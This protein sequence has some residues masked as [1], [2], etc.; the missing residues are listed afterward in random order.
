MNE[1]WANVQQYIYPL[2]LVTGS[3]RGYSVRRLSSSYSGACLR[4][5]RSSD[6]TEQDIGF[7]GNFLDTASLL[8]FVGV[9]DGFIRSWYDQSGNISTANQATS[10][11]Q[12]QIVS[13]GSLITLNNRPAIQFT[14]ASETYLQTGSQ[15]QG[16][17]RTYFLIQSITGEGSSNVAL[18]LWPFSG[19]GTNQL[20]YT[21]QTT[22]SNIYGVN[23]QG[24]QAVISYSATAP[25]TIEQIVIRTGFL[26]ANIVE[27]FRSSITV[28]D[29]QIKTVPGFNTTADALDLGALPGVPTLGY[30]GL[31]SELIQYASALSD[32][33]KNIIYSSSK[34][35]FGAP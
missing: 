3:L 22:P 21:Y 7:V 32:A 20:S 4:V 30:S 16:A 33:N 29:S 1:Y 35:F 6:N 9:G 17:N 25:G 24:T 5:R 2:D 19:N 10:A 26:A 31:T 27:F 28:T 34:N 13:S 14:A 18:I 8:T 15:A 11:L 23:A 12:P